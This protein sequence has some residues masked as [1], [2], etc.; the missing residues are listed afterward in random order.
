MDDRFLYNLRE[1]PPPH[2]E[3]ALWQKLNQ[4]ASA[5]DKVQPGARMLFRPAWAI[6][7]VLL[8]FLLG[9]SFPS[10][11][12]LAQQFLD[13]FRVQR[14]VAVSIDAARLQQLKQL[15][16][17]TIDLKSLLSRNAQVLKEPAEPQIASDTTQAS[18][19]AGMEVRLP[20]V[21]PNGVSQD[22]IR[23]AGEGLAR[24]T[25]DT[26][27][28]QSLLDALEITDVVV[29][30][31]L[32]GSSVMVRLPPRV[33]TK[34]QRNGVSQALLM[35][36]HSP[37]ITLPQGVQLPEIVEIVLRIMGMDLDEARR[38]AYSVDWRGT[39]LIPVPAQVASFREVEL[40]RVKGLLIQCK[41]H[42]TRPAD[43]RWREQGNLL[44]WSDDNKVYCLSGTI[45]SVDL[46]QM[47]SSMQ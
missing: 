5:A 45:R 26:A 25:A 9:L 34:Y 2:F 37:E 42:T 29:P 30:P 47:A 46:V 41:P 11:R 8:L 19:M 18:Q 1:D 32:N 24:F 6:A 20:T 14:F 31:E 10:V 40:G 36:A 4:T 27:I 38:F 35:Q 28:L 21:L 43:S 17:E 39:L 7:S 33:F 15:K 23:V 44:L 16:D 12:S 13:L 22:E 3:A